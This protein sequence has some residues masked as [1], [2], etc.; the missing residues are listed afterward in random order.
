MS[1]EISIL[2]TIYSAAWDCLYKAALKINSDSLPTDF[3]DYPMEYRK[4]LFELLPL[5][6]K[7][8]GNIVDI[9]FIFEIEDLTN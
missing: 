9:E 3:S 2:I 5:H 7:S 1:N 4:E 8:I 6:I